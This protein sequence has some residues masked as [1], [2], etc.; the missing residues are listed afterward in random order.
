MF[1]LLDPFLKNG[2]FYIPLQFMIRHYNFYVITGGPGVGKTTLINGLAKAGYRTIGENAREIIKE[3]IRSN[4]EALPWKNK[5]LYTQLMLKASAE[6]FRSA[7]ECKDLVFFDRGILDAFCYA[8]I[9]GMDISDDMN[10]MAAACLYN[11]KVFIL[12]P[13]KE[14]YET[15]HERKQSWK[16][17]VETYNMMKSTYSKYGY[18]LI[19]V[20]FDTPENRIEFILNAIER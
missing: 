8:H 12:P 5:E 19:E 11:P 7:S 17:A 9:I 4:G 18:E 2:F 10:D 14:I 20:P 16:E 3:Q 15:D 13:W 6:S 1:Y